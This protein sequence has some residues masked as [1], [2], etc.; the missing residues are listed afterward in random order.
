MFAQLALASLLATVP[1]ARATP[2]VT[3]KVLP[4]D[5]SSYPAYDAAS[6]TA[7]PWIVQVV[8]SDNAAIEGFGDTSVYSI[9]FNPST[10]R[11]PSLR[12]GFITFPT[13]ND[14]A[15]NQMKC[16]DGILK[17]W[18]PSDLTDAGAP[19]S[20][21]WTPL[22]LSVYPYDQPLMWKVDGSAPQV[23]EHYIGG[24]KQD[25]VFLGGYSTS[26]TWGLKYESANAGSSGQDYYYARLL[27]P[28]SADPVT[29]APLNTNETT[30]FI[31]IL[32]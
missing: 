20:Y 27:G 7:G 19:T 25:G 1:L 16:E 8:S 31:K 22:V 28:N 21:Q 18:V 11:K 3:A 14:L 6:N 32:A 17:G 15:K 23:F 30:A 4:A 9:S 12:W 2:N 5:C 26:T 29:G 10:D 24:Q 13:R